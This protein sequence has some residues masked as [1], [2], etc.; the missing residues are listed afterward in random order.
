MAGLHTFFALSE[1]VGFAG[2]TL[3][4]VFAHA[5]QARR[6]ARLTLLPCL[7]LIVARWAVIHAGAICTHETQMI[8]PI[9]NHSLSH[10]HMHM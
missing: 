7:V 5:G 4:A 6:V 2:E 9:N 1:E 10:A 8:T 3:V